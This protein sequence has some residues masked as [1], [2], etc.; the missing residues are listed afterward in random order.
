[1]IQVEDNFLLLINNASIYY[2]INYKNQI[3]F[4]EN[5]NQDKERII[6]L[7]YQQYLYKFAWEK[8]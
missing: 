3:I 4:F 5:K 6:E 1:M 7:L 2:Y 8:E